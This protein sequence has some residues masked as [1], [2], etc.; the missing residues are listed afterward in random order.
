MSHC[1]RRE[2]ECCEHRLLK[3][4]YELPT[5]SMEK[6]PAVLYHQIASTVV[7]TATCVRYERRV[8]PLQLCIHG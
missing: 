6:T 7:T 8:L 4:Q 3:N 5:H 2:F 1:A